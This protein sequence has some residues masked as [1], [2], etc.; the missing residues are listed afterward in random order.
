[1][2]NS[3]EIRNTL[4]INPEIGIKGNSLAVDPDRHTSIHGRL[5]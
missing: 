2:I 4:F 3:L 5:L 1:M